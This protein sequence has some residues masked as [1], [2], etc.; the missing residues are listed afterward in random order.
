MNTPHLSITPIPILKDN[1]VWTLID[2]AKNAAVIVDPGDAAP[3]RDYLQTHGLTLAAILLTHHHWDHTNG[4]NDLK[5]LYDVPVFGP[6]EKIPSVTNNVNENDEVSVVNFP[7]SFEVMAIPGHTL[8]H[9]AYYAPGMIFCGDTL[10]ASGCGRLFE[11]TAG[12]MYASLQKIAALPD[13]THVYCAHEYTLNNLRFAALVEPTNQKI[14]ERAKRVAALREKNLPSIPD[15]LA[16]E[17][18]T[19]P[20]LRCDSPEIIAS[21]EAYAGRKLTDPVDVFAWLRKWKD[22]F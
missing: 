22:E 8:S 10:F 5:K 18:A 1:Y 3:V 11:G 19:N 15:T 13:S 14:V 9:I 20:F 2:K 21:V 4:V 6:R 17:K 16:E 7:L 12:E